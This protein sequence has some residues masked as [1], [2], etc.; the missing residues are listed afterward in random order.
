MK[1][2]LLNPSELP[3]VI[4]EEFEHLIAQLRGAVGKEHASDGGH[5]SITLDG[6]LAL[7]TLTPP[8]LLA[9][10]DNY[11]PRNGSARAVWWVSSDASR[12]VTGISATGM[13]EG[14]AIWL[15][16][17]GAQDIVI[18]HEST[19]SYEANRFILAG[20]ANFTLGTHR[21]IQIVRNTTLRRW[22]GIRG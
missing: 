5:S 14:Q 13:V 2:D 9:N 6:S 21:G 11:A 10:V 20:S 15:F 4:R 7:S 18:V 22:L 17:A 3:L 16:N 8:M 12:N 1:L 19:A